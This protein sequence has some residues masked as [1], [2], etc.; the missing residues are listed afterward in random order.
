MDN[1]V[2]TPERLAA[3]QEAARQK[4]LRRGK[5]RGTSAAPTPPRPPT[6]KERMRGGGIV[7]LDELLA[8][9]EEIL[10][11]TAHEA[12]EIARRSDQAREA[13]K[14]SQG[15]FKQ[16]EPAFVELCTIQTKLARALG[17]RSREAGETQGLLEEQIKLRSRSIAEAIGESWQ[18]VDEASRVVAAANGGKHFGDHHRV[19]EA[20]ARYGF[21]EVID[22]RH[23]QQMFGRSRRG[24]ITS[25]GQR[26]LPAG[27]PSVLRDCVS[28]SIRKL[29]T[30]AI[31]AAEAER[32]AQLAILESGPFPTA[33]ELY[34]LVDPLKPLAADRQFGCVLVQLFVPRGDGKMATVSGV[35]QLAFVNRE[36]VGKCI[37]VLAVNGSAERAFPK[38][39]TIPLASLQGSPEVA[40]I[41]RHLSDIASEALLTDEQ[42]AQINEIRA[43]K[44]RELIPATAEDRQFRF[45]E[46]AGEI[47]RDRNSGWIERHRS[48]AAPVAAGGEPTAT[49]DDASTG[50]TPAK[51]KRER[52]G[53]GKK[54]NAGGNGVPKDAAADGSQG[55]TPEKS[56][57]LAGEPIRGR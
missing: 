34:D 17:R 22:E 8:H 37:A 24:V 55:T 29:Y 43:R 42:A 6:L 4:L 28:E 33:F 2:L 1:P 23:F 3:A 30:R 7:P 45:L 35:I 38:P 57:P 48:Q 56:N 31:E 47:W 21:W 41:V 18:R 25:R 51:P 44:Q 39:V 46:L 54:A 32:P 14:A 27:R 9:R 13:F 16:V 12:E 19:L 5:A 49:T 20:A 36:S 15:A 52:K 26:Y 10:A 11:A 50:M 40:A 53:K